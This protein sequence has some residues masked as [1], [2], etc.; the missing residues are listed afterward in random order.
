[1]H[2]TRRNLLQGM[3]LGASSV[4]LAPFM[5]RL[6]AENAGSSNPRRFVFVMEGNGFNPAQ[7]QPSTIPRLKSAQSRNDVSQLQDMKLENH[8][9]SEAMQPLNEF[10]NRLT[11]IQGLSSRICGGGH[12]NNFGA[13][14]VYSSKA[15][16]FGE[17][18][19]MALAKQL[20]S[21]FPQV[22]LGISDKAE[23]SII[24]NTSAIAKGKKV[25][26]QCQ[27][28]LA[29]QQLFGS[30]AEGA[31]VD[32][33]HAKTNLLD[34]MADDVKRL[35]GRLNSR[36]KEKLG[37]YLGAFEAMRKR[38]SRLLQNEDA[39]KSNR[40]VPTDK[41]TSAIETDRLEAQFDIGAAALISG[42]TNVLTIASGCGDPFFSIK[43]TGLDINFGKH[44]IGHGGS[45]NGMTSEQMST[46]I[47]KFHFALMANLARTL[48]S[49]P[50][51]DGTMLDNTLIIYLSDAA[52]SHHSRC[53]EWPVVLLGDLGG[54]LDT[55]GRFLCYPR[56]GISGHRTMANL[57]TSLLHAAGDR[58][59]RFGLADPKL[60]HLDQNGP[61]SELS[62]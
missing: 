38:Q 35:Q 7:A 27:P 15:G 41:F 11:V 52:E 61:L 1:M 22:G 60:D 42:L 5:N 19:D 43:F 13:L 23:H 40:P 25:P 18:I 12:S 36:E 46:K 30:V 57:Y 50:E 14:G 55:K 8:S 49:V 48:R 62:I 34:F 20:P 17:T 39:L 4:L 9:L 45:Y 54:R 59:E 21:I 16:A 58:R 2:T 53:W 33:F 3:S 32:E 28:H 29:Y 10:K 24:Y 37:D 6:K 44:S 47:R 51:G 26:T 31:A 56:Y